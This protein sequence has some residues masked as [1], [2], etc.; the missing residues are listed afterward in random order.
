MSDIFKN[1]DKPLTF[2]EYWDHHPKFQ[3]DFK[4]K[5]KGEGIDVH[6]ELFFALMIITQD[7]EF[8]SYNIGIRHLLRLFD[9]NAYNL[10]EFK[11]H[12]QEVLMFQGFDMEKVTTKELIDSYRNFLTGKVQIKIE[13]DN[14]PKIQKNSNE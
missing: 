6:R 3:E 7:D 13:D 5:C 9:H 2:H 1:L 8:Q 4:K 12:I 10:M 14:D 11:E